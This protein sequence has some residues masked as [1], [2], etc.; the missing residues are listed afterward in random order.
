MHQ[1]YPSTLELDCTVFGDCLKNQFSD[2]R[3]GFV[4]KYQ[5]TMMVKS[6]LFIP[7]MQNCR[8]YLFIEDVRRLKTRLSLHRTF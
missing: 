6:L 2:W 1:V 4:K 5:E 8:L 7:D 3:F